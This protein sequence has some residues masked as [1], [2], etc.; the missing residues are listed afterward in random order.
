MKTILLLM[1]GL[2]LISQ[3]SFGK[4][5]KCNALAGNFEA[6]RIEYTAVSNPAISNNTVAVEKHR[7]WLNLTNAG[8]AFKQLLVGY[9]TGA[10][11][12][13]DRL[14]DSSTIDSNPYIDF[15]SVNSDK[16]LTIQGRALPFVNTDEVPLGYRT[17][18]AGQFSIS[19]DHVD[20]LFLSTSQDIFLKDLT[21]GT[22]H[23]LRNGAYSLQ[24]TW[25]DL[26]IALY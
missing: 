9:I 24:L 10:T 4:E 23:N 1:S 17:A 13:W 22:I 15:Y 11:N 8:G 16:N 19:I 2:F 6:G 7:I 5:I 3:T 14:Y 26:M 21:T 12:G 18:V 20:G 25:E